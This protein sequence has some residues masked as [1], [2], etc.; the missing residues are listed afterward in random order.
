MSPSTEGRARPLLDLVRAA[1]R[2]RYIAA[3]YAPEDR[4]A[5]LLA[6]YAFNA[7]IAG[8]RDRI[9]QALPGEIRLQW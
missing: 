8:I 5:D 3:L 6:L 4:R 2:D 9:S 7:E 1:D